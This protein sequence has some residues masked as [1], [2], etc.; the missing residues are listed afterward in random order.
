MSNERPVGRA[1][2]RA[3][4]ASDCRAKA[5]SSGASP[6]QS[7]FTMVEIAISL[8]V[9]GIA[10]VAIIGVL[11]LGMNVQKDNREET[12]INQDATVFM[13]AIRDGANS[14]FGA[15]LTNYV[16]AI[17][18]TGSNP[19]GYTNLLAGT[20]GFSTAQYPLVANWYPILTNNAN[21]VGLLSMPEYTGASIAGDVQGQP[22]PSLVFGGY[23]NHIV[24]YVRSISGSAVEKPPQDNPILQQDSFSY[25]ILFDNVPVAVDTNLFSVYRLWQAIPY[26][27]GD[28]VFYDWN[29]WQANAPTLS[30]DIP[31]QSSKWTTSAYY[32]LELVQNLHEL[33]LTFLWP[34]LPNG[35]TGAGRQSFRT[36]VGGQ[37]TNYFDN[38]VPLYFLQSQSFTNAP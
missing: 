10:L 34:L 20:M 1:S 32:P 8:A 17:V 27:A 7:G 6:H 37:I 26:N 2:P 15:D 38:G 36:M 21:I 25:K 16:Y 9:I 11:P 18:N 28:Q 4:V 12:I 19:V 35:D 22:I 3:V 30:S 5:G 13:N 23:S 24:A 29:N 33:R 14:Q 31:G